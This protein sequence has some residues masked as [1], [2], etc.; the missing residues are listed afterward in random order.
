MKKLILKIRKESPEDFIIIP[1]NGTDICFGGRG[2][3]NAIN[4]YK[5]FEKEE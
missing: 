4:S 2:G 3:I 1:Q 5:S